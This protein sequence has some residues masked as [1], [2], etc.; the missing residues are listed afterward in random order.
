M[1]QAQD[2]LSLGRPAGSGRLVSFSLLLLLV[3]PMLVLMD[4]AAW[5]LAV[6]SALLLTMAWRTNALALTTRPHALRPPGRARVAGP[7]HRGKARW[8]ATT[9]TMST[10]K[11][12]D[13]EIPDK[14]MA[15]GGE[16]GSA[17]AFSVGGAVDPDDRWRLERA[18]LEVR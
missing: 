16:P 2:L 12:S 9:P 10:P 17:S 13:A 18:R 3:G 6:C 5:L 8:A 15:P 4:R 7:C 11:A 1:A 14:E